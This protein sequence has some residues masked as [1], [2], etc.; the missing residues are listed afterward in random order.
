MGIQSEIQVHRGE[1]E[2]LKARLVAKGFSQKEGIDFDETFT[3]VAKMVT[4]RSIAALIASKGG[5][6][7]NGCSQC[8]LNEDLQ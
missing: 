6:P 1:V 8:I 7:S 2:R 3:P 4:V 5:Y